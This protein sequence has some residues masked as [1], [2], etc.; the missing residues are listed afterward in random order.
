MARFSVGTGANPIAPIED[1]LHGPSFPFPGSD[2]PKIFQPNKKT[3]RPFF[4]GRGVFGFLFALHGADPRARPRLF[5]L[6]SAIGEAV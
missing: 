1:Y 5:R 6:G 2:G 3:P 4:S